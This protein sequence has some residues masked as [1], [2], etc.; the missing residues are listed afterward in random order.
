MQGGPPY[1]NYDY[2]VQSN[3]KKVP[4]NTF[5]NGKTHRKRNADWVDFVDWQNI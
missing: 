5:R 4:H 3:K 1:A 2:T